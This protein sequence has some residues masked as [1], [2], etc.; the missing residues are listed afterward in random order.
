M[1]RPYFPVLVRQLRK[2][3]R[4]SQLSLIFAP[5]LTKSWLVELNLLLQ[6]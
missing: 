3:L 1:G 5:L 4:E 2:C 6:Q